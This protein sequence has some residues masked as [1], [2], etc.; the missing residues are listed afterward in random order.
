[1]TVLILF[2]FLGGVVT[3]LS[4]CILPILPI[5][6]S[7]S[8]GG[9]KNKPYGIVLGFIASFTFFTLF[10]TTIVRLTGVSPNI[11][12][13]VSVVIL[14]VFGLSLIVPQ[15]QAKIEHMFSRFASRVPNQ[16]KRE[17]FGGGI[18]VGFSLGLL[19]TP[20]VGPILASVITL[21][22]TGSVNAAAFIITLAYALGTALPM[23]AIMYGGRQ[24]LNRTPWLTSN[25]G[26]I[27][28]GFGVVMIITAG[29]ILFNVDRG[30]QSY[31][32]EKFPNYGSGLTSLEDN[33]I[34][35]D[36]LDKIDSD[37][38]K[39]EVQ[40]AIEG[41]DYPIAP[42]LIVGGE[43]I[44][45]EPLKL[46]DL[47]GKV[48]LLDVMTYSC[49]NCIRTFPYL[50]DWYEKYS[51]DGLVI[52]GIHTPEFEFEK[53]VDNVKKALDDFG[54]KFPV[55]QDNDYKTWR[56]YGNRYWPRKYLLNQEG[57]IVYD[58][59]GEGKY[60]ET[61]K[62]I[63]ELL[64]KDVSLS[65]IEEESVKA[66]SPETYFGASRNSLLAN[67]EARK[68]GV[69]NFTIP[70]TIDKN[71]LYLGGDWD[72]RNEYASNLSAGAKIVF[73]YTSMKVFMV[74]GSEEGVRIKVN[75]SE[76]IYIKE[77][78]L[79]KLLEW[80]DAIEG[81]LEIEVLDPGLEVFTFTFG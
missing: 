56:A 40:S 7:G 28:K 29:L 22:L 3:I 23:L 49:I 42:E 8:V 79:Y 10:L 66:G 59:I 16:Q 30:I 81:V 6:L 21:A 58:H 60:E 27:Q 41:E 80:D 48:V 69:Q 71:M 72:I 26:N 75:G 45:S 53:D 9:G 38:D 4:P 76:E 11:L 68:I 33:S 54:I 31:L 52:I 24:L 78:K 18:I 43:W 32:L 35:R 5:I 55:M 36:S 70:E 74:A 51:D 46:S 65:S 62:L 61:E 17:G 47:R 67:G 63:Q 44:N 12:R 37:G 1:M 20:C 64:E 25:L 57:R 19:W 2:A 77:E 15:I 13:N 39:S 14:A 73:P 34:V 50:N